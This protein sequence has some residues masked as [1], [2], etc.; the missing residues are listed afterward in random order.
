MKSVI[1]LEGV[2]NLISI[3]FTS[4]LLRWGM[5]ERQSEK[6]YER[7]YKELEKTVIDESRAGNQQS[8]QK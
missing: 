1:K 3:Y 5:S 6:N 7:F 4:V 2:E 8:C